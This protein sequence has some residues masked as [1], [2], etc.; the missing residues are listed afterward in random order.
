D[1]FGYRDRG[2]AVANVEGARQR[3]FDITPDLIT[4]HDREARR[5]LSECHLFGAP[6]WFQPLLDGVSERLDRAEGSRRKLPQDRRFP[7]CDQLS[8]TRDQVDEARKSESVRF[9]VPVDIGVVELD[10]IDDRD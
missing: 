10:I 8:I 6:E 9:L 7:S 1:F 3:G 5:R 4:A 2:Q